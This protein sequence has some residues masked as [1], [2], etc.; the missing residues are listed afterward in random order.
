M[1]LTT[2]IIGTALVYGLLAFLPNIIPRHS[3]W[4]KFT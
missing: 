2:Y 1:K 3:I 4:Y